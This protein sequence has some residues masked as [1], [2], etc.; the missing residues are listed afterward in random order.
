MHQTSINS[1]YNLVRQKTI[2]LLPK[3]HPLYKKI[4]QRNTDAN[5]PDVITLADA[6][7]YLVA[8]QQATKQKLYGVAIVHLNRGIEVL[9]DKAWEHSYDLIV[10]LYVELGK[11]ENLN[12]SFQESLE[13]AEVV[14]ENSK[15]QPELI[16]AYELKILTLGVLQRSEDAITTIF[17]LFDLIGFSLE[18]QCPE[19]FVDISQFSSLPDME[20]DWRVSLLRIIKT[21]GELAYST[22]PQLC[23]SVIFTEIKFCL[24]YG[25]SPLYL[26][27]FADYALALACYLDNVDLGFKLGKL[28]VD[29]LSEEAS[30]SKPTVLELF[31]GHIRF[32][33]DS[34]YN[35]IPQLEEAFRA[36]VENCDFIVASISAVVRCD[37]MRFA[38]MGLTLI[39]EEYLRYLNVFF[40]MNLEYQKPYAN[41]G[42]QLILNLM[43]VSEEIFLLKGERFN[44]DDLP[45]LIACYN[46]APVFLAYL[47]KTQLNYFF[48]NAKAAAENANIAEQYQGAAAGLIT[49]AE[50]NFYQSLALLAH[51]PKAKPEEQAEILK[52]VESSQKQMEKWARHAPMNFRQ[53]FLLVEAERH[54]LKNE[55]DEA[56][57][58]YRQ[59]I[60][61]AQ[62]QGFTQDVALANELLGE[63]LGDADEAEVYLREARSQ[64]EAWGA[65]A[66]VEQLEFKHP[67]LSSGLRIT[68][69]GAVLTNGSDLSSSKNSVLMRFIDLARKHKINLADCQL[70]FLRTQKV[71][72]IGYPDLDSLS[73]SAMNDPNRIAQAVQETDSVIERVQLYSGRELSH[74][75]FWVADYA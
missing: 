2:S 48:G 10:E 64:Y 42:L 40:K 68:N 23:L 12:T 1:L 65:H 46:H 32:W 16:Q 52:K 22:H 45:N 35:S 26:H 20:E 29:N 56:M 3:A 36:G 24:D 73:E 75:P 61:L 31:N 25:K 13:V 43:G 7:L 4:K 59:A 67:W 6:H 58:C 62:E 47:A 60:L 17:N 53:R 38:G 51:H 74:R 8:A 49:N 34:I 57:Q 18:K 33:R 55:R 21:L 50:H 72:V 19:E 63:Y 15:S 71:L 5:R 28:A 39:R 9:G 54:R 37:Q 41:I 70:N 30:L 11:V 27:C 14:I 44:E 69:S 66:K